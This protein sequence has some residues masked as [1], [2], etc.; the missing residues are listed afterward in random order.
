MYFF[1]PEN[2]NGSRGD[3]TY[4][5]TVAVIPPVNLFALTVVSSVTSPARPFLDINYQLTNGDTYVHD[6]EAYK[7]F[8]RS[9][10]AM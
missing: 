3:H 9:E 7:V 5:R 6:L 4:V 2:Y 8:P 10:R 1:F